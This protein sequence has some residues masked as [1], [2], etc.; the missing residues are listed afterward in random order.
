MRVP[1]QP[2]GLREQ[3]GVGQREGAPQLTCFRGP[4]CCCVPACALHLQHCVHRDRPDTRTRAPAAAQYLSDDIALECEGTPAGKVRRAAKRKI[5]SARTPRAA[6]CAPRAADAHARVRFLRHRSARRRTRA[7]SRPSWAFRAA[8]RGPRC[9]AW[10]A[11]RTP[12]GLCARVHAAV[13]TKRP[14]RSVAACMS[15]SVSRTAQSVARIRPL[16]V[17]PCSEAQRRRRHS[18]APAVVVNVYNSITEAGA[19]NAAPVH[20]RRCG[21][22]ARNARGQR[23]EQ[24]RLGLRRPGRA[25]YVAAASRRAGRYARQPCALRA[26]GQRGAASAN[27]S[28]RSQRANAQTHRGTGSS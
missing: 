19:G 18:V 28:A 6:D 4:A 22:Y 20:F 24:R 23:L 11:R 14:A 9:A 13:D 5:C 7:A 15:R 10:L 12:C 1:G 2:G 25:E 3:G 27:P 8:Q 21:G 17:Q 26:A 16:A